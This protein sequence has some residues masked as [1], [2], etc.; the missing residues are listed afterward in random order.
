MAKFHGKIGFALDVE[1]PPESGIWVKS[2][3]EREYYGDVIKESR[4]FTN[5][6][7]VNDNL[8]LSNR[9]SIISDAFANANLVSLA[10]V[11]VNGVYWKVSNIDI[12]RPR[13]VLSFGGV[14]NGPKA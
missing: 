5:A 3:T 11:V 10:Y 1:S 7:Q 13:L 14:Y 2:I 8:T 9:V 12:N 4:Q 6:S